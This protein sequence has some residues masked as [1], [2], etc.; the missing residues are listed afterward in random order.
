MY[1]QISFLVVFCMSLVSHPLP[2]VC[3]LDAG[4][5]YCNDNVLIFKFLVFAIFFYFDV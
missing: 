1:F 2:S 4:I 3:Y 5:I